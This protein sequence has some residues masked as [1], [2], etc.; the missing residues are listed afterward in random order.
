MDHAFSVRIVSKKYWLAKPTIGCPPMVSNK[1]FLQFQLFTFLTDL[2]WV[3]FGYCVKYGS[4]FTLKKFLLWVDIYFVPAPFVQ[5]AV[6]SSLNSLCTVLKFVFL[7][8]SIS[9]FYS[10]PID[11]FIFVI[12]ICTYYCRLA[13]RLSYWQ[14][15]NFVFKQFDHP[16]IFCHSV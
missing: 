12:I 16:R 8:M 10:F 11:L 2:F 4:E 5:K 9:E 6:L 15:S 7:F 3:N 14:L 13:R 1:N